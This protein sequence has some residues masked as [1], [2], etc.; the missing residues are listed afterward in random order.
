MP[1]YCP[2]C[3]NMEITGLVAEVFMM[4]SGTGSFVTSL[5]MGASLS[6]IYGMLNMV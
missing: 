3:E 6:L 1:S 2:E 5:T 4:A